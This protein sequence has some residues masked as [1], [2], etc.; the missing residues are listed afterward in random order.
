MPVTAPSWPTTALPT[1]VRT[2]ASATRGSGVCG[3][4]GGG[5]GR[6]GHEPIL[7]VDGG[8]DAGA[9]AE[10]TSVAAVTARSRST[11]RPERSTR[12]RSDVG[13]RIDEHAAH[14]REREAGDGCRSTGDLVD[15]GRARQPESR[16][17][18]ADRADAQRI[19]RS[20]PGGGAGVEPGAALA[21]LAGVHCDGQ[22]LD[23][24]GAE[25]A[26]LPDCSGDDDQPEQ[27]DDGGDP[28]R[29]E[30][31]EGRGGAADDVGER[32]LVPDQGGV[33]SEQAEGERSVALGGD[34]VVAQLRAVGQQGESPV[35]RGAAAAGPKESSPAKQPVQS[36]A[37]PTVRDFW[38]RV[39]L[40]AL[41]AAA[42]RA[43]GRGGVGVG[44][45]A[46]ADGTVG[47]GLQRREAGVGDDGVR[48]EIRD[49][50][51][52]VGVEV[53]AGVREEQA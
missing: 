13:P 1:S 22:V 31:A 29:R 7:S 23:D 24:E 17:E 18:A 53:A 49:L 3:Q 8:T 48:G 51:E 43:V 38:P 10:P 44:R 28:V 42:T 19:R 30:L 41:C 5:G 32:R 27:H 47:D 40:P 50:A 12:A 45:A 36:V 46:G 37:S 14:L 34:G 2:R 4:V 6:I 35:V 25:A 26:T 20:K 15:S 52:A 33:R 9:A 39:A 11:S 21:G 16:G